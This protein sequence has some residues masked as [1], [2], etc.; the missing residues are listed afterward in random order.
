MKRP[1][2]PGSSSLLARR[3]AL[4]PLLT[5]LG[6]VAGLASSAA[7][8]DAAALVG[9]VTRAQLRQP[10]YASWFERNYA[11]GAPDPSVAA[12]LAPKLAGISIEAYFGTWCGDSRRQIPRLARLLDEAQAPEN[13]LTLIGLSD[14]TGEFKQSPGRPEAARL[15]HRTPTLVVLREGREIGRIV[16]TPAASLGADLLAILDGKGKAPKYPAEAW[17]HRLFSEKSSAEAIRALATAD[18][19]VKSLGETDSLSHYAEHDLLKNGRPREAVALLELYLRLYPDSAHGHVL[20]AEAFRDL[21]RAED[22]ANWARK[23]LSLDKANAR[24]RK[25]L[26]Q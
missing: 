7:A 21:G 25:L 13:T 18:D 26:E 22:S 6:V 8:Q 17:V 11:D 20:M 3:P 23:A 2:L 19:Q 24:A 16:E 15:V 9:P 1:F 4:I 14:R 12:S 5:W 10:P